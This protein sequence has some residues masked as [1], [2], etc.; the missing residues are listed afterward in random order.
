VKKIKLLS[1][2]GGLGKKI[3]YLNDKILLVINGGTHKKLKQIQNQFQL[4]CQLA[5]ELLNIYI[6]SYRLNGNSQNPLKLHK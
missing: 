2:T 5:K 6:I 1:Q 3:D 4:Y